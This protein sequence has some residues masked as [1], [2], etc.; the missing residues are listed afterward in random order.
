[1]PRGDPRII[2]T[3]KARE[4]L[5]KG[6]KKLH[7]VVAVTYGPTSGNVALQKSWGQAVVTK[8][9][10]TVAR[11]IF[12]KDEVED[13]GA[14]FLDEASRKSNDVTGDGT[15]ATVL[16]GYHIMRLA[17]QRIAAGFNPIG[18]RRGIDK[19]AVWIK[20]ELDKLAIP[21]KDKDLYRVS[22]ISAS[23]AAIGKLVADTIVKVK[24]VGITVEEYDGLGVIQDVIDGLYFEKGWQIPQFV[25]HRET[26]EAIL[27]NTHILIT[28]KTLSTNQDI[29]PILAMLEKTAEHK[30]VVIIGTVNNKALD[31]AALNNAISPV[32]IC[33]VPPPV[34]GDQVL[35]FLEDIAAMTGGEVLPKELPP[36]KVAL[37]Q[38]GFAKKVIV[39]K[40]FTTILGGKIDKGVVQSRIRVLKRQLVSSEYNAFQ[41]ERMEMRLA[42]LQGKIG[43]IKVGGATESE[44]TELKFRVEDAIHATRAAREE[45]IVPGGAVALIEVT[46][47]ATYLGIQSLSEDQGT[48]VVLDAIKELFK[49]LME[50]AGEDGG[51]RLQQILKAKPNYGFNIKEMTKEPIDLLKAGI[52]DPVKVIKSV[53]ENACAAAGLAITT[54]AVVTI[55][56][57]FQLQQKGLNRD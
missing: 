51:Y 31:A 3:G 8:D 28:E 35:P 42:K 18:L 55:D 20:D 33:V 4:K 40:G 43:I 23:D 48:Y 27:E 45:G 50:N 19:A 5:L 44:R 22:T 9:G 14:G 15:T 57:E 21:I 46:E 32:K 16:L 12:L 11:D 29:V 41:K 37:K 10:V 25:T 13:M 2:V 7:D 34:Y 53:V 52:F 1:M 36:S 30:S 49:Q 26:E 24:G 47:D 39:N 17:N 6:A 54:K 56:R 38:L